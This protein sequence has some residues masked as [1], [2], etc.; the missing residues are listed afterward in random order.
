MHLTRGAVSPRRARA[1]PSAGLV[2]AARPPG[3]RWDVLAGHI[4][5]RRWLD[6]SVSKQA[7]RRWASS[8]GARCLGGPPKTRGR[9][10]WPGTY[11][12]FFLKPRPDRIRMSRWDGFG[13]GSLPPGHAAPTI[14]KRLKCRIRYWP[15]TIPTARPEERF[16]VLGA[17][18]APIFTGPVCSV[19]FERRKREVGKADYRTPAI[20]KNEWRNGWLRGISPAG[21]ERLPRASPAGCPHSLQAKLHGGVAPFPLPRENDFGATA[22]SAG[23][24]D[25]GI[26]WLNDNGPCVAIAFADQA[27]GLFTPFARLSIRVLPKSNKGPRRDPFAFT[28]RTLCFLH[29]RLFAAFKPG[30]ALTIL[31]ARPWP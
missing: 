13:P 4:P 19:S 11:R 25:A 16:R 12:R 29:P 31:R 7:D 9:F 8:E 27:L 26:A 21:T 23:R 14:V 24:I 3:G 20:K 1:R 17:E 30:R 10:F 6:I 5:A 28:P 2:F 15:S 22:F 18:P